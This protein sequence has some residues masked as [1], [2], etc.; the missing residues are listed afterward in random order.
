MNK[1]ALRKILVEEGLLPRRMVASKAIARAF[2]EYY[3]A[4]WP[5]LA[6]YNSK[7][8]PDPRKAAL[9]DLRLGMGNVSVT[10]SDVSDTTDEEEVTLDSEYG[11]EVTL[12]VGWMADFAVE[13]AIGPTADRRTTFYRLYEKFK[14]AH[15]RTSYEQGEDDY[16]AAQALRKR[17]WAALRK[18]DAVPALIKSKAVNAF[19][20]RL[21]YQVAESKEMIEAAD[22]FFVTDQTEGHLDWQ[23]DI[24]PNL[25]FAPDPREVTLEELKQT[26]GY[27]SANV[28][29]EFHL[30]IKDWTMEV[31]DYRG[32]DYRGVTDDY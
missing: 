1:T 20:G 30:E 29:I 17:F 21:W 24:T 15:F 18:P 2:A 19:R 27:A 5:I 7:K 26:G 3:T 25:D 32:A 14:K 9:N 11:L 16:K 23:Y 8:M 10:M 12:Q 28:N 6:R 13:A 22:D 31:T 4:M